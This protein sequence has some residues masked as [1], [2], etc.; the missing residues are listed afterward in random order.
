MKALK[1]NEYI[2][3]TNRVKVSA[4]LTILHDVLT[5]DD[6]GITYEQLSEITINLRSAEEKLFS[7]IE[8][9]G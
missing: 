8:L 4:A 5:G 7:L 6:Y 3:I 1:E 9:N 2:I